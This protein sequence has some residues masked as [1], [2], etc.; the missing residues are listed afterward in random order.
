MP[1][2][3]IDHDT[4]SDYGLLPDDTNPKPKPMLTWEFLG[5]P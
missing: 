5:I 1:Y 3:H 2:G 4:G